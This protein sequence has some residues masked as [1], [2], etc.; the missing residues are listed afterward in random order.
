MIRLL[1]RT[2]PVTQPKVGLALGGGGSKG[3]AHIGVMQVLRDEGIPIDVIA[4]TSIGSII[5]ALYSAG[6]GLDHILEGMR[7][8]DRRIRRWR[9]SRLS[10]W[11]DRGL[12]DL[13]EASGAEL[14]F[15]D[16][17]LPFAAVATDLT[18]GT[19]CVLDKGPLWLAVQA[20]C[21]M[22]GIFPPVDIDG[23]L[24]VDGGVACPVPA[25]AA[26]RLGAD[27]VIAVDLGEHDTAAGPPAWPRGKVPGPMALWSR[28]R[29][30]QRW[31]IDRYSAEAANVVIK[32]GIR[33]WR[34]SDFSSGG[35]AYMA[36]GTEAVRRALPEITSL[37]AGATARPTLAG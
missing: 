36:A 22:P 34:W 5:G 23:H 9:L 10:V 31:Q 14:R 24:L 37:L 28:V 33:Q 12:R 19:C 29:E 13:L 3:F 26:R 17:W 6:F 16:L 32:P 27:V 2:P 8:A 18:D 25:Q 21:A 1:Q 35:D 4:G 15:E 30:I 20:S 11:S 7:G